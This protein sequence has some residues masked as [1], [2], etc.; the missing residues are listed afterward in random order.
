[1]VDN[2]FGSSWSQQLKQELIQLKQQGKMHLNSTH[3]VRQDRTELLEKQHVFEA[4][5]SDEAG[6][7][8][9]YVFQIENDCKAFGNVA[10]LGTYAGN[11]EASTSV[12]DFEP[13]HDHADHA[14][15]FCAS[16]AIGLAS[17]QAAVQCRSS[18][19][20]HILLSCTFSSHI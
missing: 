17:H 9:L 14:K 6:S 2:L 5:L 16:A 20:L 1:M 11:P 19:V 10:S 18:S 13:G 3:L 8:A 7:H 15:P 4:E 12:P